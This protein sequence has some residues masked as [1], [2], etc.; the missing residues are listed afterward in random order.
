MKMQKEGISEETLLDRRPRGFFVLLLHTHARF[1][2]IF[3]F[4]GESIRGYGRSPED[5]DQGDARVGLSSD[6][7]RV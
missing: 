4:Q 2:Y 7:K 3:I 1:V 5:P 6:T